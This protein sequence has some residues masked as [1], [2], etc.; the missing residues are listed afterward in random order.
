MEV[1]VFHCQD[2]L[3][4]LASISQ[5]SMFLFL[6][7]SHSWKHYFSGGGCFSLSVPIILASISERSMFLSLM[8]FCEVRKQ[9]D[10]APWVNT[11]NGKI[12]LLQ[13]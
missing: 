12:L 7:A 9:I 13:F 11:P 3:V 2:F 8:A 1:V 5:R 6:T 10:E 4:I